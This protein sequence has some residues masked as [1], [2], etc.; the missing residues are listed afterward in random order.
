MTTKA[1]GSK[2]DLVVRGGRVF[3]ATGS[4]LDVNVV[5]DRG[6]ITAV[7]TES[8]NAERVID[9]SGM[10][11]LPG[12][13]D[14]H[15]HLNSVW[16]FPDERRPADD[17]ASGTRSAVAGGVTAVCDFVY[18]MPGESLRQAVD[19]VVSDANAK[20]HI[21]FGLHVVI[22]TLE[23][24]FLE[25]LPAIVADGY[26]SFKFY[27]QLPDFVSRGPDYIR[28][29]SRLAALDVVAM[30]HCEDAAIIDYCR[31]SLLKAG[32]TAPQHYPKSKPVEVEVAAT[33][34][35]LNYCAVAGIPAYL[36][37]LSAA[38]A[39]AEAQLA[40]K[41]GQ[42]VFVETR[43][44]YLYLTKERFSAEDAVAARYVGTPPLRD[45]DDKDQLWLGLASGDVDVVASDHVGFT[46]A[47]KHQPGDTFE[48]VPKGVA[49]LE[50]IA[51]MLYSEGV[52]AGRI[53]LERFVQLIS[54]NPAKIFGLYPRKGAIAEGSDADLMILNPADKRTLT[55]T[56]MHSASDFELFEGITVNGWPAFTISRG[57]V[58]YDGSVVLSQAGRGRLI[59]GVK[60][61]L[62]L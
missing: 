57:E 34:L 23:E 30:F 35:A 4:L 51:P 56:D 40:R 58:V 37:H 3:S 55:A 54:T 16:P 21:D 39:L 52:A 38:G 19:R 62:N 9:A 46:L 6:V 49:N 12:A 11:V 31:S 1:H 33:A 61:E 7:T 41:R 43:P 22:T 10:L 36:V 60:P 8:P 20:S 14:A 42:K 13:I 2:Y 26:P 29:L 27:T 45:V 28:L 44:L 15:T 59:K 5:V 32:L 47:Q 50:T 17:F 25:E 18:P 48:N 53:T 24:G